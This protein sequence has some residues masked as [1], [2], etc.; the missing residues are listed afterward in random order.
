MA[1]LPSVRENYN[2]D[3]RFCMRLISAIERDNARP[4]TWRDDMISKLNNLAQ[5]FMNAPAARKKG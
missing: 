3:A 5:D 2:D 1:R 4:Q